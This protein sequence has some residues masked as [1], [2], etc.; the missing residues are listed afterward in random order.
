MVVTE[1][2]LEYV[3]DDALSIEVWGHRNGGAIEMG[4]PKLDA[5]EKSKSLQV[6]VDVPNS[7][8][9]LRNHTF[10][11]SSGSVLALGSLELNLQISS[12]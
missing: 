9:R 7:V 11:S 3:Q 4:E 8:Y 6:R 2:F 10:L 5:E 12:I 1:E